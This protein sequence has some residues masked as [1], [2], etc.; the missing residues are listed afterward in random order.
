[1]SLRPMVGG[2]I[3]LLLL[4]ALLIGCDTF[5][6][7]ARLA[8]QLSDPDPEVRVEALEEI[9]EAGPEVRSLWSDVLEMLQD[10]A[11]EVR[12]EAVS[13][14]ESLP[15]PSELQ[16]ED[17]GELVDLAVDGKGS[18]Q[19]FASR[20]LRTLFSDAKGELPLPAR[21]VSEMKD[22]ESKYCSA[23]AVVAKD[24]Y[25]VASFRYEMPTTVELP[26]LVSLMNSENEL[27]RQAAP[28]LISQYSPEAIG[29]LDA[30]QLLDI[31]QSEASD[32]KLIALKVLEGKHFADGNVAG[33]IAK[34]FVRGLADPN[35]TIRSVC[36]AALKHPGL[37]EIAMPE[38]IRLSRS[39]SE[40]SRIFA[41]T[42]MGNIPQSEGLLL[43][44]LESD[45]SIHVKRQAAT[46]LGRMG[47]QSSAEALLKATYSDDS[48]L[49]KRAAI[50]LGHA[51]GSS[52]D[53]IDRLLE[54]LDDPNLK[55]VAAE[56]IP[57]LGSA[58]V[59]DLTDRLARILDSEKEKQEQWRASGQTD[60]QIQDRLRSLMTQNLAEK[61]LLVRLLGRIGPEASEAVPLLIRV[62][63]LSPGERIS[64]DIRES[65]NASTLHEITVFALSETTDERA[66]E[67]LVELLETTGTDFELSKAIERMGEAAAPAVP[68]IVRML[69]SDVQQERF[70][71][72]RVDGLIDILAAIGPSAKAALPMLRTIED[73]RTER[74]ENN[75]VMRFERSLAKIK[76]AIRKIESQ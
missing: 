38:V 36:V 28:Y 39:D 23:A 64:Q 17:L 57:P 69:E 42:A 3:P 70:Q 14:L 8:R 34:E 49:Q 37:A 51:G 7:N 25:Q 5:E 71:A 16:R 62:L 54:M 43:V 60:Q 35:E 13:C 45:P 59:A 24:I 21:L 1:M 72:P 63:G 61:V 68:T 76:N 73:E 4:F 74:F 55:S 9:G 33:S 53:A 10:P 46:A 58:V 66:A 27:V 67:A 40:E 41:A 6:P 48:E 18:V 2:G 19:D 26:E 52:R 11:P 50:S 47:G 31:S 75:P 56:S 44:M 65:P 29:E 15:V 22:V 12:A 32:A 30:D 20:F